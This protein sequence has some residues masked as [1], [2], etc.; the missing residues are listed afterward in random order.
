MLVLRVVEHRSL[1]SSRQDLRAATAGSTRA[2]IFAWDPVHR[3]LGL[4]RGSPSVPSAGCGL[5]RRH[6]GSGRGAPV[7]PSPSPRWAGRR[8][9]ELVEGEYPVQEPVQ[10]LLDPVQFRL[11]LWVG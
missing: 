10:D 3:L 2:R 1:R 5:C 9:A 6:L 7:R 4:R 11:A 8:G